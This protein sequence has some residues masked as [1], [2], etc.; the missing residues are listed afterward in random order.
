MHTSIIKQVHSSLQSTQRGFLSSCP[1]CEAICK[2]DVGA[3]IRTANICKTQK[4]LRS[5]WIWLPECK[6]WMQTLFCVAHPQQDMGRAMHGPGP[7]VKPPAHNIAWI[8]YHTHVLSPSSKDRLFLLSSVFPHVYF[9][10][11]KKVQNSCFLWFNMKVR[12]TG[13][14]IL[15]QTASFA[16][17]TSI[18]SFGRRVSF[19]SLSPGFLLTPLLQK[20][21]GFNALYPKWTGTIT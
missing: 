7:S 8:L 3:C 17:C 10:P 4:T 19:I 2:T 21:L 12:E 14:S 1:A 15:F 16:T 18:V 5:S 13:S 6:Q 20:L 9:F 11:W